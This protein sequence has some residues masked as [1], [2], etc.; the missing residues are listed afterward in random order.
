MFIFTRLIS[1]V[2]NCKI[3]YTLPQ[4]YGHKKLN[5]KNLKKLIHKLFDVKRKQTIEFLIGTECK[6]KGKVGPVLN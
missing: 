5:S 3:T 6:G 2:L 4:K 1:S